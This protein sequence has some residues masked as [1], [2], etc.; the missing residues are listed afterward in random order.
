MATNIMSD[1]QVVAA[2]A[3]YDVQPPAGQEWEVLDIGSSVWVGVPPNAVPQVNAGI[4]N[5]L[6]GPAWILRSVDIRGWNRVQ[7]IHIN[8]T[9]YLRLNNPGGAGANISFSAIV[10]RSFGSAASYVRTQLATVAAAGNMDIQ[11]AAGFEYHIT[12]AGSS[13]WIGAA[14][15]GLPDVS[16]QIFDG[17]NAATMMRGAD[18]RGWGKNMDIYI[19]N[20]N[21]L[22]LTNTN[23]A[24]AILG[25]VG[26]VAREFG[27]GATVVMTDVQPIAA[28][29]NW[30]VQPALGQEW[31]VVEYGASVWV[32]V[33]PAAL[34]QITVSMFDG[35]NASVLMQSTDVKGWIDNVEHYFDNTNYLRITDASGAGLNACFSATL[36]RQYQ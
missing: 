7:R 29:A 16:V 34:P 28:G 24:Q 2:G 35:V 18:A 11:P 26:K 36:T 14:P 33:S 32:G 3:N 6:I 27:A 22:R 13:L 20:A 30:D 31:K 5:G 10:T 19:N 17:V 9:N 12:D 15:A 4:F 25:V 21:Y 1:I 23:V 8:N